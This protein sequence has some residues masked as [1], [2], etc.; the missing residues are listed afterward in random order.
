MDSLSERER[1]N[2]NWLALESKHLVEPE[3]LAPPP[4]RVG[5]RA[6]QV[7]IVTRL[8]GC[9]GNG[10]LGCG[11]G[12]MFVF[13]FFLSLWAGL[14]LLI[15]PFGSTTTGKIT[16]HEL[17]RGKSPRYGSTTESYLLYFEFRPPGAGRSY[18]GEGAVNGETFVKLQNGAPAKVRYFAFAPGLRPFLEAGISPWFS[19]LLLGPLGLLM[20][21]I[22]G[23]PLLGFL[24]RPGK[25]L[26]KHGVPVAALIVARDGNNV[27]FC[28]RVSNASG[29]TR[30]IETSEKWMSNAG[31]ILEIGSTA[32]A[33]FDARNP[34][35][36]LI[37][38]RCAW[39]ARL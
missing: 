32:T 19:I 6:P 17:T 11:L 20:L 9:L 8:R 14:A 28:F 27:T 30:V 25:N 29:A 34:Q 4:R 21:V 26:V 2:I 36:A 33:L 12:A 39:K 31:A 15:L 38:A 7:G 22:G 24:P 23:L 16:R 1:E 35:R 18:S 5:A 10:C 13:G 37:Y 3:L